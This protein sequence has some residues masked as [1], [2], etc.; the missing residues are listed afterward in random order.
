LIE[1]FF[2]LD[3]FID[4]YKFVWNFVSDGGIHA[5]TPN[6]SVCLSLPMTDDSD[7]KIDQ[8]LWNPKGK[9]MALLTKEKVICCRVGIK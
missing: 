9:A 1:I 7:G 5:W 6:G 2:F 8:L 4:P 3:V